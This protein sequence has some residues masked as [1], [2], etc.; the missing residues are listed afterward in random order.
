MYQ[1][2][3]ADDEINICQL[4]KHLVSWDELNLELCGIAYNGVEAFE[5]I[6]RLHPQIVISD[7]RM[8]GMDGINLLEKI[9]AEGIDCPF[10]LVSGYRQFEYAQRA[11]QLGVTDY[12]VK[13]IKKKELNDALRKA[14]D[15]LDAQSDLQ[16][17]RQTRQLN[18]EQ[19]ARKD[20]ENLAGAIEVNSAKL[21]E[22]SLPALAGQYGLQLI[23]EQRIIFAKLVSSEPYEAE[24]LALLTDKLKRCL[25]ESAW[26]D[27][28][29]C[30]DWECG[31][32]LVGSSEN[33]IASLSLLQ[34]K[35]QSV[36]SV[37]A[38]WKVVLGG[39]SPLPDELF[40][41]ALRRA[42][43][44]AAQHYFR[45][46]EDAFSAGAVPARQRFQ[47]LVGD[48]NLLPEAMQILDAKSVCEQVRRGF[49]TLEKANSPEVLFSYAD[50][51]IGAMNHALS[52][53]NMGRPMTEEP[54]YLQRNQLLE[55]L[56]HCQSLLSMCERMCLRLE[57]QINQ[58]RGV[59][60]QT[61]NKPVRLVQEMVDSR[62]MEQISLADAS[63]VTGL[64]TVYLS[65]LFKKE[66]GTNFKD[67]LTDVR[68]EKAKELLRKGRNINTVAEQVGYK[69][70]KYFSHLFAKQVGI[71]PA[72][73]KKLYQWK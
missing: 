23:G 25:R 60:E 12:I 38:N 13:P 6:Q 4:I 71:N 16:E 32:L 41:Q 14:I 10:I 57:H 36:I 2:L 43:G 70:S 40:L 52:A 56:H 69:D 30:A 3:V 37:F 55:E 66:T 68:M 29:V 58:T 67:Y 5:S 51:V 34:K 48:W 35:C 47:D 59:I 45:P 11:I 42:E 1:V 53:F 49:H 21:A 39:C 19:S 73:Y 7:I 65:V 54:Q 72:Q 18:L 61:E 50:W 44:A 64:T 46:S 9:R 15:V 8:S 27:L 20:L 28:F 22:L 33:Q 31:V 26:L 24:T 63:E 62:Y 17:E